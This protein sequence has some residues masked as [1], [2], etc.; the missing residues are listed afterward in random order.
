MLE[1]T[2][3]NTERNAISLLGS[4]LNASVQLIAAL[5]GGWQG[6]PAEAA[7]SAAAEP[8]AP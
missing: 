6:L 4:R 5:G 1:T 8:S 2:A 3:L 7:A